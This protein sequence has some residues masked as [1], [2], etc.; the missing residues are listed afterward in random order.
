[1]SVDIV[2]TNC[3]QCRSMVQYCF[4]STE[5][6]RLIRTDSPG[7]PPR[8]SRSSWILFFYLL[9]AW[10]LFQ[11]A[12]QLCFRFQF[13]LK[14]KT[15][16]LG[17]TKGPTEQSRGKDPVFHKSVLKKTALKLLNSVSFSLLKNDPWCSSN[18]EILSTDKKKKK[19]R[20]K[21]MLA[22]LGFT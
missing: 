10:I 15:M 21:K 1:M 9:C 17:V 18:G 7:Q 13:W 14:N 22:K 11:N 3:D 2:G 19:K 12:S 8:L 6:I 16:G 5:T 4:T 20:R